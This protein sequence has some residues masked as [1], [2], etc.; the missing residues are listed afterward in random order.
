MQ[1]IDYWVES[2]NSKAAPKL[3]GASGGGMKYLEE[4]RPWAF[5]DRWREEM[6]ARS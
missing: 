4:V 3:E 1:P 5:L 2:A 6:T